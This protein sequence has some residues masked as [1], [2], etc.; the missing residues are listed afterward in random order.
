[1]CKKISKEKSKLIHN[2][3]QI[4]FDKV[5]VFIDRSEKSILRKVEKKIQK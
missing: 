1:M 5:C 2:K 4:I 3:E